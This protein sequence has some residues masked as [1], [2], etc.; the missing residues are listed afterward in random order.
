MESYVRAYYQMHKY[1]LVWGPS[2]ASVWGSRP[3]P[4]PWD[5]EW[6]EYIRARTVTDKDRRNKDNDYN[7]G[8]EGQIGKSF[9]PH[10]VL[11]G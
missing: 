8:L 3:V 9:G 11:F 10:D 2:E 6:D 7:H 4:T 1:W 5:P